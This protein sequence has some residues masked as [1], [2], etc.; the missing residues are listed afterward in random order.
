MSKGQEQNQNYV[1]TND[2]LNEQSR[3]SFYK[4]QDEINERRRDQYQENK[5]NETRRELYETSKATLNEKGKETVECA[6]GS[7]TRN[8]DMSKHIKTKKLQERLRQN[9]P[10][11][12]PLT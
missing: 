11:P 8:A 1:I 2:E 9:Q 4:H 6:C 12:K 10:E 3:K 5:V 7:I